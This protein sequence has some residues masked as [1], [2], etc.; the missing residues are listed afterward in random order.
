MGKPVRLHDLAAVL[1]QLDVL[2]K[3]VACLQSDIELLA[4]ELRQCE[5]EDRPGQTV[6][7]DVLEV[8]RT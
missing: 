3:R 4:A 7:K 1:D 6:M 2:R 8:Q 5:A